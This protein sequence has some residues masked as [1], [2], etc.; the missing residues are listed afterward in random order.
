M[1]TSVPGPAALTI[2]TCFA[3]K[4]PLCDGWD[5]ALGLQET[6]AFS[7]V[8]ALKS[9]YEVRR[10]LFVLMDCICWYR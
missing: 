5:K 7:A 8:R 10:P 6:D 9:C 2:D 3:A 1:T 4:L